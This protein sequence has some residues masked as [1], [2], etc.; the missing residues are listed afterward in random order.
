MYFLQNADA[1]LKDKRKWAK[2]QPAL[3]YFGITFLFQ[4]QV[5]EKDQQGNDTQ[6]WKTE[7]LAK[8]NSRHRGDDHR[9][10]CDQQGDVHGAAWKRKHF[11]IITECGDNA[12]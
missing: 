2:N 6:F 7:A 5:D 9:G 11:V 4:R 8:E 10:R 1:S 3:V 12:E